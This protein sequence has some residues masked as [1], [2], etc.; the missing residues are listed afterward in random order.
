MSYADYTKT[1]GVIGGVLGAIVLIGGTVTAM[2]KMGIQT[3]LTTDDE[4]DAAI[5]VVDSKVAYV[6]TRVTK[7][8]ETV[9]P[10][11]VEL[12]GAVEVLTKGAAQ[13]QFNSVR[14][15]LSRKDQ[16]LY[17]VR[18]RSTAD[19]KRRELDLV[20]EIEELTV[21][22]RRAECSI[23]RLDNPNAAC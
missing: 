12:A 5:K 4:L 16:Q 20:R 13:A 18:Q 17:E 3:G 11:L 7:H 6:D 9:D 15:L 1:W 22:K 19:A 8:E 14:D 2:S 23:A 21:E 10:Q